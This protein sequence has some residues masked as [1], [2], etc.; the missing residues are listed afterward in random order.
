[1][2]ARLN[3]CCFRKTTCKTG[4]GGKSNHSN[5]QPEEPLVSSYKFKGAQALSGSIFFPLCC[6]MKR[7][8]MEAFLSLQ[9]LLALYVT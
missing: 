4:F 6:G 1:M 7:K 2:S 5:K 9:V 8:P 3:A